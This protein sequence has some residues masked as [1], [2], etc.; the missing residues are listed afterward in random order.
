MADGPGDFVSLIDLLLGS[1]DI[2]RFFAFKLREYAFVAL[3]LSSVGYSSATISAGRDRAADLRRLGFKRALRRVSDAAADDA[4][5]ARQRLVPQNAAY[6]LRPEPMRLVLIAVAY[7][8]VAR[9]YK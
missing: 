5:T 6:C 9:H 7:S 1:L 3:Q 2:L 4:G 8:Y